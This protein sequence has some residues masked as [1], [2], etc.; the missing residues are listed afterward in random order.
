MAYVKTNVPLPIVGL[1]VGNP[2]EFLDSRATPDCKNVQIDRNVIGKRFGTTSVGS[3]LSERILGFAELQ[4]GADTY[5]VRVGTTKV[6]LLNKSAN[7]WSD[8]TGTDLT[9]DSTYRVD[10]AFPLL[11]GSKILTFTNY[12]DAIRKYTGSGNTANLGGTPPKA[13]FMQNF[14]SYLVLGYINDGGTEYYARVQWCDTGAP[15]T[16]SG[17]N[18]GSV[19]LMDDPEDITGLGTLSNFLT[20]HKKRSIYVGY[21]VS[22]SEVFR[23]EKKVTGAGA[24]SFATIQTLPTGEQMFLAYDGFY[25]FN[26][27]SIK[28]IESAAMDELRET[29]NPEYIYRCWSTV[30]IERN[31]YWC[32]VPTGNDT[33]PNTIYKYNY[34][35]GQLYKDARSNIS[36][37]G[38]Y[39][40]T[41][42]LSWDDKVNT[43]DSDSTIWNN[44]IYL[45]LNPVLALGDTSGNVTI[46]DAVYSD[47]SVAYDSYWVSKDF[48][49]SDLG[50]NNLGRIVRWTE[51]QFW[52]RGSALTIEYSTDSGTTWTTI[53]TL[54]LSADYPTDD[55]P[56]FSYFDVVSSKIRFR[57]SN[58]TANQSWQLKK[59]VIKAAMREMRR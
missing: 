30:K 57:F 55:A 12:K 33:E 29:V 34:L 15:E 51:L 22:T 31:E 52:A 14:G 41:T 25:L 45:D 42:Q 35:T 1:D 6:G 10:F 48:T 56:L 37:V 19:D 2:G 32:A 13:K 16:W 23:F 59:F 27:I 49:A 9:A 36:A 58:N 44:I 3:S 53:E 46:S 24:A 28:L 20:V 21:L 5:F 8:I 40:R 11:S 18:A 43:W 54:T 26:G 39:E 17:G 50:D 4:I 38:L 47:N 7:T